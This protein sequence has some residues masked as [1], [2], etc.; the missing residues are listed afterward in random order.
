MHDDQDDAPD[1]LPPDIA[2]WKIAAMMAALLLFFS[3]VLI[4]ANYALHALG[5][6]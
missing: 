5:L 3:G 1:E 6:H 4:W 2:G